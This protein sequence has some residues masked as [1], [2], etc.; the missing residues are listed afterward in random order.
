VVL[1][2]SSKT[3]YVKITTESHRIPGKL[4]GVLVVSA[5]GFDGSGHMDIRTDA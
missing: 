1:Q 2:R 4:L 5:F 3:T